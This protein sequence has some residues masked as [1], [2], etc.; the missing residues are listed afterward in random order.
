MSPGAILRAVAGFVRKN[1]A[2]GAGVGAHVAA[3]PSGAVGWTWLLWGG[4]VGIVTIS[5]W[6]GRTAGAISPAM[7]EPSEML[8][9][10]SGDE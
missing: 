5:R 2:P 8:V 7:Q 4:F 10:I 9:I 1:P 3:V 6:A